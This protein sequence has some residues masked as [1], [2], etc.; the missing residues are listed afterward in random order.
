MEFWLSR[1]ATVPISARQCPQQGQSNAS[2]LKPAGSVSGLRVGKTDP[3][4]HGCP[5]LNDGSR[6][7]GDY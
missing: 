4:A 7:A 1:N 6:M 3:I 5:L 2:S